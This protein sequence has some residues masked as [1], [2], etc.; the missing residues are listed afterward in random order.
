MHAVL[1]EGNVSIHSYDYSPQ[2]VMAMVDDEWYSTRLDAVITRKDEQLEWW[3]FKWSTDTG[4]DRKGRSE[5]QLKAQA[6]AAQTNGVAYLI[7]TEKDLRNKEL[8]FDNWL[9]LCAAITRAK[10]HSQL[11]EES[12]L[13][14]MFMQH[15]TLT[16]SSVLNIHDTDPALMLAV[17]GRELQAGALE[18]N[19]ETEL[20]GLNSILTWRGV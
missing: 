6:Q 1:L 5:K 15:R 8:L 3:E 12:I 16:L 19:L 7:K 9:L 11:H 2:P 17:V 14:R 10:Y 20:F 18:A 13:Q 4:S